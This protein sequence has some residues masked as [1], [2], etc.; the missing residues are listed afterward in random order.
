[1]LATVMC[2]CVHAHRYTCVVWIQRV[3]SSDSWSVKRT[4]LSEAELSWSSAY[5]GLEIP[6][7]TQH[8]DH[9]N[10][11]RGTVPWPRAEHTVCTLCCQM[12]DMKR[13]SLFETE[14]TAENEKHRWH[15]REN[16]A[17][18]T[19]WNALL[20]WRLVQNFTYVYLCTFT[21]V[22]YMWFICII[23]YV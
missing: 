8:F 22:I 17:K 19:Q 12:L 14:L 5:K 6:L 4:I 11:R 20:S 21:N 9:V 7:K 2:V 10:L 18:W 1:M 23:L 3:S 13:L 15:I 16:I